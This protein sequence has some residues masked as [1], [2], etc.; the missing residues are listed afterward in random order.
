MG[1]M[2]YEGSA[3]AVLSAWA[4]FSSQCVCKYTVSHKNA[5]FLFLQQ[6]KQVDS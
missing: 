4:L 6:L 1:G 2:P 5:P 3:H